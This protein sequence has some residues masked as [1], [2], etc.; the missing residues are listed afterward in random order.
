MELAF[1]NRNSTN[2]SLF[3]HSIILYA[4]IYLLYI[5]FALQVE[6]TN[7]DLQATLQS[8]KLRLEAR[9]DE[10]L[11]ENKDIIVPVQARAV[12]SGIPTDQ[13]E[14]EVATNSVGSNRL[15][16]LMT[17]SSPSVYWN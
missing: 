5:L 6:Q 9:V 2:L 13:D 3:C 10:L 16:A 7:A 12:K 11:E 14:L 8:T 17:L 4:H 1:T 15:Q